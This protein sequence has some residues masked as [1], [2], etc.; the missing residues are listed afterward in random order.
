[1]VLDARECAQKRTFDAHP[2]R[3]CWVGRPVR[4]NTTPRFLAMSYLT[5]N[6]HRMFCSAPRAVAVDGMPK[7]A[8]RLC[9]RLMGGGS[10]ANLAHAAAELGIECVSS[11]SVASLCTCIERELWD[12][13]FESY[14]EFV[15]TAAH[16]RMAD[17]PG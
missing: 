11:E 1:M 2:P 3:Y 7:C 14:D 16:L 15:P 5:T 12:L 17:A 8:I 6:A 10:A 9:R 13:D 4:H